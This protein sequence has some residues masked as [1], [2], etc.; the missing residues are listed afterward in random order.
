M[1]PSYSTIPLDARCH[2]VAAE[3]AR[4]W[5]ITNSKNCVT[6]PML[7]E[8]CDF[9]TCGWIELSNRRVCEITRIRDSASDGVLLS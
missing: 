1:F 2:P 3:L 4:A 9:V 8:L 6:V 5:R 7:P